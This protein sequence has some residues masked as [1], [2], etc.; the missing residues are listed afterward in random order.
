[1]AANCVAPWASMLAGW[2]AQLLAAEH[3]KEPL[4]SHG[5]VP[6]STAHAPVRNG[7]IVN[8]DPHSWMWAE[9]LGL[10]EEADRLH[11]QFCGLA[12]GS[13]PGAQARWEPPMDVV[14]TPE[15]VI[16]IVAL[17][18]V[19]PERIAIRR[20]AD[21]L[22]HVEADRVSCVGTHTTAVRCLE[23]PYGRFERRIAL[24]AGKYELTEQSYR[25][26]CLQLRLQK[27]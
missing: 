17:P 3:R 7:L 11:R 24:P 25:N 15:H 21:G 8:R 19:E 10:L 2:L 14:E 6:T 18:G 20:T 5:S 23:I 22:L 9:A 12:Q 1:V 4:D 27:L 13:Q 16:V 26:G